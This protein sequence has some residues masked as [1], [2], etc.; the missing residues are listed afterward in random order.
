MEIKNK[1]RSL[2]KTS[3]Q[4]AVIPSIA[5]CIGL[6]VL[7]CFI[8]TV[9]FLT[10]EINRPFTA[11]SLISDADILKLDTSSIDSLSRKISKPV[12]SNPITD[13][14]NSIN[15]TSGEEQIDLLNISVLNSTGKANF[16]TQLKNKLTQVG[17]TVQKVG[18]SSPAE[19]KTLIKIK[20]KIATKYPKGFEMLKST[21]KSS[22]ANLAVTSLDDSSE[23]DVVIIIGQD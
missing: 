4:E 20:P 7:V 15:Q 19:L 5:L 22:Y 8:Y 13:A 17:F 10:K 11:E 9:S 2:N 12:N 18:D 21:V 3:L 16:A 6:L 14:E 23:F 1:I